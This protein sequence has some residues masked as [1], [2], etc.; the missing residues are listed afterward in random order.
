[1]TITEDW[2]QAY[3]AFDCIVAQNDDSALGAIEALKTAKRLK[4]VVVVGIDGSDNALASVKAGEM[5]MT[6]F[7]DAKGQ[8]KAVVDIAKKIRDGAK[9]DS[10]QNIYIPFKAITRSNLDEAN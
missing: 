9:P 1:M 4:G 10:I 3:P 5:S 7:Q 8:A 6:V 2:L